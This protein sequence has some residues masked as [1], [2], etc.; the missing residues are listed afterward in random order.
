V[1]LPLNFKLHLWRWLAAN[2]HKVFDSQLT[3]C[4]DPLT[5]RLRGTE[6]WT[7][8][9]ASWRRFGIPKKLFVGC[10]C[11]RNGEWFGDAGVL[12]TGKANFAKNSRVNTHPV[13]PPG[14]FLSY[15][16]SML[17]VLSVL[18]EKSGVPA[19]E[20]PWIQSGKPDEFIFRT[21]ATLP[22]SGTPSSG[23]EELLLAIH[24]EYET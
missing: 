15:R 19:E 7:I 17:G 4:D 14:Y 3:L 21:L 11:G 10:S 1:F 9:G 18:S 12:V 8:G 5:V 13:E 16:L 23:L 22:M 20:L 2:L 6:F 24:E